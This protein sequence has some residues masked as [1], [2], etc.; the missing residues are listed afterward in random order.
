MSASDGIR[1]SSRRSRSGA[2]V[3]GLPP[4][5]QSHTSLDWRI[6]GR[7][8]LDR[9]LDAI[10]HVGSVVAG[11]VTALAGFPVGSLLLALVPFRL[12][13]ADPESWE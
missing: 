8:G 11:L 3:S 4:A 9:R 2:R 12:V 10:V 5:K 6:F 1:A 7:L 13:G